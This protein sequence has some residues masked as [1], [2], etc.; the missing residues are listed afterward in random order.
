M[1]LLTLGLINVMMR[2]LLFIRPRLIQCRSLQWTRVYTTETT[3][4]AT[5]NTHNTTN[6]ENKRLIYATPNAALV[7][8]AK[9]FSLSTLGISSVSAPA[10]IYFW[11]SPAIQASG[12]SPNLFLGA[13]L[14]SV[15]STG[16]LHYIL[17]PFIS[18]IALHNNPRSSTSSSST[19]SHT[20]PTNKG[21]TPNSIVTLET[22]DLLAR[23]R[24]TT[25]AIRDLEPAHGLFQTW[26]VKTQVMKQQYAQEQRDGT[27]PS[28]RQTR[29]WLDR[30]GAGDQ[31]A[32]VSMLRII[33]G[34][35]QK[36]RII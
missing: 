9:V 7:K 6:S 11:E 25:L 32:M 31:E 1:I 16:A 18:T 28:I 23:Q 30:R 22:R 24:L 33:Q 12:I 14:A 15:C 2:S 8:L 29:F 27:P 5:V 26:R 19:S 10:V 35:Q 20:S 17:S 3:K 13:L 36:Q 34:N 4:A 21:L